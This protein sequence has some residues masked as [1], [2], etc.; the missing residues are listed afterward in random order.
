M[1]VLFLETELTF[2]LIPRVFPSLIDNLI[3][4]LR[5]EITNVE[6]NPE[7]TFMITDKLNIKIL[8]QP[9]DF[10]SQNKY[11]IELKKGTDVI[12]LGKLLILEQGTNV[13]NYEYGSQT[14]TRFDYK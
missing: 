2:S 14:K 11:E 6:I 9:S 4:N 8:E 10:Q 7:I 13:Q 3:L 5:N 12:Y 1:K